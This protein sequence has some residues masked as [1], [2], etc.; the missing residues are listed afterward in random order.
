MSNKEV[1][2][3]AVGSQDLAQQVKDLQAQVK[4]LQ[5]KSAIITPEMEELIE[6]YNDVERY[7]DK[8]YAF[9]KR[10]MNRL[11]VYCGDGIDDVAYQSYKERFGKVIREMEEVLEK[12]LM[13]RLI[14]NISIY[15]TNKED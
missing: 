13:G 9:V 7:G 6:L 3:Q 10:S 14:D 12:D 4:N 15:S 8:C 5:K 11:N 2:S 1:Q